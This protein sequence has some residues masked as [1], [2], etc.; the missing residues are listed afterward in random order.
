[1]EPQLNYQSVLRSKICHTICNTCSDGNLMRPIQVVRHL[2]KIIRNLWNQF[3]FLW[4]KTVNGFLY[5]AYVVARPSYGT[6][7]KNACQPSYALHR[8]TTPA[9][10]WRRSGQHTQNKNALNLIYNIGKR[11]HRLYRCQVQVYCEIYVIRK[12]LC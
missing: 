4:Y 6:C 5:S 3:K 11:F 8:Y 2:I 9:S 12:R 10:L 7:D 1:M